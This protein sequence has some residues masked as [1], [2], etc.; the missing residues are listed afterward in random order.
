MGE[1]EGAKIKNSKALFALKGEGSNLQMADRQP[2]KIK[3]GPKDFAAM[4]THIVLCLKLDIYGQFERERSVRIVEKKDNKKLFALKYINKMQCIKMNA[5]QN[6]FRE[7][8]ILEEVNHPFLVNLRFAFQDD[9]N[10]FMVLDL[11]VGGDIRYHLDRIGGFSENVVRFFAAELGLALKYLHSKGIVHRDLKPDNLLL[12]EFGHIHITDFNIAVHFSKSKLLK[13]HSGTLAYMAPDVLKNHGYLWQVDWWSL[14]IVLYECI[15]GKR[16]F[17]GGNSEAITQAI[18]HNDLTFPALN[19]ATKI[20]CQVSPDCISFL[21]SLLERDVSQRLGCTS[22]GFDEFLAH[23]WFSGWDWDATEKKMLAPLFVPAGDQAN[24]DATHDLEELLLDENPLTYGRKKKKDKGS[25]SKGPNPP[26]QQQYYY[27]NGGKSL[28]PMEPNQ[29]L[30]KPP[31]NL[32]SKEKI[33]W[34]LN[35]IELNFKS[36][37]ST[38]YEQ[39]VGIVDNSTKRVS[40]PP[41]WVRNL[42]ELRESDFPPTLTRKY[43]KTE[44][45]YSNKS[46]KSI[47]NSKPELNVTKDIETRYSP[48][49]RR[50]K[51]LNQNQQYNHTDAPRRQFEHTLVD[52]KTIP[53]PQIFPPLP[54]TPISDSFEKFDLLTKNVSRAIPPAPWDKL[55]PNQENLVPMHQREHQHVR[56]GSTGQ[57]IDYPMKIDPNFQ[58]RQPQEPHML[59]RSNSSNRMQP[60]NQNITSVRPPIQQRQQS[61]DH[62]LHPKSQTQ[63]MQSQGVYIQGFVPYSNI[64][65]SATSLLDFSPNSSTTSLFANVGFPMQNAIAQYASLNGSTPTLVNSTPNSSATNLGYGSGRRDITFQAQTT[66]ALGKKPSIQF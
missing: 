59:Y 28:G 39:Y 37:D 57:V 45:D 51:S 58:F 33:Q 25:A 31:S 9:D 64:N 4:V 23:P 66:A 13:S 48:Q 27:A 35:F 53:T 8:A 38:V 63:Q 24:F 12:D 50:S 47:Q 52:L 61:L 55:A 20:K 42:D 11:M 43:A 22:A 1:I 16:P 19:L 62:S 49:I 21:R 46:S 7:R 32:T 29:P 18:L 6:I 10:M 17:R 65:G 30:P 5:I 3:V 36:F 2:T 14:G 60:Q 34:E 56:H 40:E 41:S 15:Y 26:Q 54:P 44:L